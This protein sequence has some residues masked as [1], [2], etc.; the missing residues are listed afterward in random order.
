MQ[1][2]YRPLSVGERAAEPSAQRQ[3]LPD[4]TLT[5][6]PGRPPTQRSAFYI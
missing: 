2:T 5:S 6:R 4:G 1:A 3:D